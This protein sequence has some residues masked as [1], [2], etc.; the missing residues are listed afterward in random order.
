MPQSWAS[1]Y[2]TSKTDGCPERL[3]EGLL[4][5]DS[6]PVGAVPAAE[7]T[8]FALNTDIVEP[9][10]SGT[11]RKL[12]SEVIPPAPGLEE[13]ETAGVESPVK[14]PVEALYWYCEIWLAPESTTYTKFATGLMMNEVGEI[15]EET[16]ELDS[17]TRDPSAFAQTGDT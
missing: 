3:T 9:P 13:V 6:R 2:F 14:A 15:P 8:E 12:P 11:K 5:G 7:T 1:I 10:R 17:G 4:A 16:G